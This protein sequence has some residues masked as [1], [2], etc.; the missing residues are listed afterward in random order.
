MA[1]VEPFSEFVVKVHGRCN[2]SCAYCYVYE[3]RDTSWRHKPAVLSADLADRLA[4]RIAEH[5]GA[6]GLPAVRVVLHGGEPLLAGRARIGRL[7]AAVRAAVPR[8]TAVQFAVQT[9]GT[10]LNPAWMELFHRYGVRVGVSLDGG[11]EATDRHR[12]TRGGHGSHAA[13]ERGL[14][15]LARE[16]N[17]SLFGGLLCAVDLAN[18][19]VEVY[20]DLLRHRPPAIDL[21]L[22]HA[23]WQFPPPGHD[24]A[25][26]PYG[27]WLV[28]VFDRW[29][30]APV[31][32]TRLRLFETV[33]D[34]VLGG[35]PVAESVGLAAP[36]FVV[37][38][39]DGSIEQPDSLKAAYDG[40][41]AT[42]LHI[43]A[44]DF[45]TAAA[46]PL[47]RQ[48][49]LGAAGLA[50]QCLS[51]PV[52]KLCGGGLRAHRYR[53]GSGFANPSVYCADLKLLTEHIRDRVLADA[54]ALAGRTP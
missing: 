24:P 43:G 31:R 52:V 51:C 36:P 9:N 3:L 34:L 46:H 53:P 42:G 32:E 37:V 7:L 19:P 29:Y 10:L 30:A 35:S 33:M 48:G 39:T 14:E 5:A 49:R 45:D 8:T 13:V 2:L 16:E 15:L 22:P 1:A 20:E 54:R 44:D 26:A 6:H 50:R 41:A 18:D 23:T 27:R 47:L 17:A 11:R 40:A 25:T 12:R 21:L 38:D 4:V 28:A